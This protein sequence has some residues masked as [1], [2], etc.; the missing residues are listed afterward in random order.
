M[1][2][3]T[4]KYI[5]NQF[6]NEF[7]FE[8]INKLELTYQLM[9][10]IGN[11]DSHLRDNIIY[12]CLAHLLHD[13]HFDN[14]QLTNITKEL[15]SEKYLTYDM[16]N[17]IEYSV[18]KRSFTALQIALLIYVHN[19]DNIFEKGYVNEIFNTVIDYYSKETYLRGY[20]EAVGWIHSIAHSADMFSR[21][22]ECTEL[23]NN[24]YERMMDEICIK[25]QVSTY[26]YVS[27]EDERTVTAIMK[28]LE[29]DILTKEYI[30]SWVNKL[31]DYDRP[32]MYPEVYRINSNV[33]NLLRSLYFRILKTEKYNY[34]SDEIKKVLYEK[35]QLK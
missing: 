30:L 26:T 2:D 17:S 1:N 35:V 14:N 4:L 20:D 31:G 5:E 6:K 10:E 32:K 34:L 27:D 21:L 11:K 9:D 19:R 13:K 12:P 8:D 22:V 18:L 28:L 25:F 7:R 23:D 16:D 24:N 3:E 29:R 33:K 15:M